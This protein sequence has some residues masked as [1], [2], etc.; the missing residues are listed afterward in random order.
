[1]RP[2]QVIRSLNPRKNLTTVLAANPERKNKKKRAV[3]RRRDA[4]ED[5][6]YT[7]Q[8][9]LMRSLPKTRRMD[10][11]RKM[12]RRRTRRK[13]VKMKRRDVDPEEKNLQLATLKMTSRTRRI[14]ARKIGEERGVAG[15]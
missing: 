7:I 12:I 1:M 9:S 11:R 4:R 2:I 13:T 15:K 3:R 8:I 6:R 10:R 14:E 5:P